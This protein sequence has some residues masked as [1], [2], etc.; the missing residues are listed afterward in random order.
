MRRSL[1]A[2]S[3]PNTRRLLFRPT[4]ARLTRFNSTS[5]QAAA[6]AEDTSLK[7]E[8][9]HQSKAVTEDAASASSTV[10]LP[11]DP[12]LD[13]KNEVQDLL[14]RGQ[15]KDAETALGLKSVI[16]S[17]NDTV[18]HR[19]GLSQVIETPLF[20]DAASPKTTQGGI[21]LPSNDELTTPSP[22]GSVK[23]LIDQLIQNGMH[24]EA[25]LTLEQL[26]SRP[27][28]RPISLWVTLANRILGQPWPK[29]D[30]VSKQERSTVYAAVRMVNWML[31]E[32]LQFRLR[33]PE[34][35]QSEVYPLVIRI[36]GVLLEIPASRMSEIFELTAGDGGEITVIWEN[37]IANLREVHGRLS[38]EETAEAP[39]R[40]A[41]PTS[42]PSSSVSTSSE[43][44]FPGSIPSG[45]KQDGLAARLFERRSKATN[46]PKTMPHTTAYTFIQGLLDSCDVNNLSSVKVGREKLKDLQLFKNPD[47]LVM[48]VSLVN[49]AWDWP[50]RMWEEMIMSLVKKGLFFEAM[51]CLERKRMSRVGIWTALL[52]AI[53][54]E[55]R[56]SG[57]QGTHSQL[58]AVYAATRIVH[59]RQMNDG[60]PIKVGP[61]IS[62]FLHKAIDGLASAV[63]NVPSEWFADEAGQ[64][65]NVLKTAEDKDEMSTRD[66]TIS[67]LESNV[68]ALPTD[69][70]EALNNLIVKLLV[71]SPNDPS[72]LPSFSHRP[73]YDYVI[74]KRFTLPFPGTFQRAFKLLF[75]AYT[76]EVPISM[77]VYHSLVEELVKRYML[78]RAAA[79][80]QTAIQSN[81]GSTINDKKQLFNM[82]CNAAVDGL[83]AG[84]DEAELAQPTVDKY[85]VG[86]EW[87]PV[88]LSYPTHVVVQSIRGI[89]KLSYLLNKRKLPTGEVETLLEGI[90]MVLRHD[91]Q[92][93][94]PMGLEPYLLTV[95]RR[96]VDKPPNGV[97]L[98]G[99]GARWGLDNKGRQ[100]EYHELLYGESTWVNYMPRLST[101]ALLVLLR[102]TIVN[103]KDPQATKKVL[104]MIPAEGKA[105][106][107]RLVKELRM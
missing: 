87:E 57:G 26:L 37:W 34:R 33:H 14:K 81:L 22:T 51:L 39:T 102:M 10:E 25:L 49:H 103:L 7:A 82:V 28:A 56:K 2:L 48:P 95:I 63:V 41:D 84:K 69:N 31:I 47:I 68:T 64:S 21:S 78:Q 107:E 72:I 35:I 94:G 98:Q 44:A 80:V 88:P 60:K 58:S 42:I 93:L 77:K 92:N 105:E 3:H 76:R 91:W 65:G 67:F 53:E 50:R 12:Y 18:P 40:P 45:S 4:Q 19:L 13:L 30:P 75:D 17:E 32:N 104:Q 46:A 43:S 74:K 96:L 5:N 16:P 20:V 23:L 101:K 106:A 86:D 55:L 8:T 66:L 36:A 89:A 79:V 73:P 29:E 61:P 97:L 99:G 1:I 24:Y 54:N 71:A 11:V 100:K 38:V 85:A 90:S 59:F 9:S 27:G 15:W 62:P 83:V 6:V 52:T 70:P